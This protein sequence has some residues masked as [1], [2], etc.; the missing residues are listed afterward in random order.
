IEF[1]IYN[2]GTCGSGQPTDTRF[3]QVLDTG[4]PGDGIGTA[5]AT[6]NSSSENSYCVVA[7]L[8]AGS[9]GGTNQF[10]AAGNA[11]AAGITFSNNTGQF[12]TGGGWI[13]DPAGGKGNFG[14]NA[15]YNKSGQPQG[16]MVYVWRGT[17]NGVAADYI[18]KSNSLT[19]LQFVGTTYPISAT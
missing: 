7:K 6:Y 9:A 2:A 8:V 1:D 11:E 16:Q 17:Y 18:I 13:N 12:V 3:A 10:Y 15:R 5:S 14:F 19:A 4:T